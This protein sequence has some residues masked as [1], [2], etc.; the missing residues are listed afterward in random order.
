MSGVGSRN[1]GR[2]GTPRV[3][4][5]RG[6]E[7]AGPLVDLLREYGVEPV[8]S[9]LHE[10][11]PVSGDGFKIALESITGGPYDV[12]TLTSAN[13]VWGLVDVCRRA[14]GGTDFREIAGSVWCVGPATR[15]A[16]I[17]AGLGEPRTA[18]THRGQ[19]M[20]AEL[21]QFLGEEPGRSIL[22]VQGR[23]ARPE[24]GDGLRAAGHH[25]TDAV[26]Y[27]RRPYPVDTPLIPR[28]E[29][30][31][32]SPI[33][34]GRSETADYVANGMIS[35]VI[36]TSPKLL[37]ALCSLGN[38][39]VPVVCIGATTAAV[40]KKRGVNFVTSQG[41]KPEDLARSVAEILSLEHNER[42]RRESSD[43]REV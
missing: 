10:A 21:K 16:A 41:T 43:E 22:C 33:V 17:E 27:E 35:A 34:V 4:V 13:G 3:L 28:P 26:V 20:V 42:S 30:T 5:T 40:A 8:L 23:P 12:L 37:E 9:P 24:L 32:E 25:V 7:R 2:T 39:T 36:A 29:P 6:P 1:A 14:P 19:G 38:L 18:S 31:A 11:R 15:T